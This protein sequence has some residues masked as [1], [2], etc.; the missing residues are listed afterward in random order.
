MVSMHWL[1]DSQ[2]QHE[3][4]V[5]PTCRVIRLDGW[6]FVDWGGVNV[7]H[8]W[9]VNDIWLSLH[10]FN[11]FSLMFKFSPIFFNQCKIPFNHSISLSSSHAVA[12][13]R[14]CATMQSWQMG[15][16]Q[17]SNSGCVWSCGTSHELNLPTLWR[18]DAV[19]SR[20]GQKG[21][22]QNFPKSYSVF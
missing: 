6:I 11:K 18:D 15:G 3:C 1:I 21:W 10:P 16:R 13:L 14:Y 5:N 17:E 4:E 2:G 22:P 9:N 8:R 20:D 7:I 12:G 19:S